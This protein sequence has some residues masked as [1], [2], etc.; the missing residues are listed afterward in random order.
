LACASLFAACGGGDLFRPVTVEIEGL[1]ARASQLVLM[2][3]AQEDGQS[4]VGVD[5]TTSPGLMAPHQ[6]RWV[7]SEKTPRSFELPKIETEGITV[8]AY[9]VDSAGAAIQ[10]GCRELAFDKVPDLELGVLYLT[11][12]R[13]VDAM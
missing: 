1:S 3:F 9:S 6:A 7:R 4:C 5:L 11:L 12:S 10:F 2:I 13:R 8:V